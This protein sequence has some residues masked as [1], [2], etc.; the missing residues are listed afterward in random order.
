VEDE[1]QEDQEQE[2][3]EE[4]LRQA[5]ERREEGEAL[6]EGLD[7]PARAGSRGREGPDETRIDGA[8]FD[9]QLRLDQRGFKRGKQP[10]IGAYERVAK[11]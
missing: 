1:V 9:P 3:A 7:R 10:D 11:K 6:R 4:V 2:E 8:V 5:Q